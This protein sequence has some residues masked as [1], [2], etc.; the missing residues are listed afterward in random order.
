MSGKPI[1]ACFGL[2]FPPLAPTIAGEVK[3][4]KPVALTVNTD[5]DEDEPHLADRGLT[6]Y[7]ARTAGGKTDIMVARRRSTRQFWPKGAVLEDYVSTEADDRSCFATEGRFP[8]FLYFATKKDRKNTNFDIYVAVRHDVGKAWSA[9]T[10]VN[11][12]ATDADELHPWL[13]ADG[14]ALF[15][16]RKTKDGWRVFVSRRARA[17][18]AGGWGKPEPVAE[19]P[20]D[21]HHA[22]LTPDGKT[23]YLQG[24][25]EKD[26][27]GLFVSTRTASGWGKPAALDELNNA[28]GKTG[29]RSPNLSRDGRLLYFASD[30]PVGKGGLDL[31]YVQ[32]ALLKKR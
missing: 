7:Y 8:Q 18:V 12:I 17:G 15:F 27:W 22:T 16:S 6:L 32:R 11:A 29:D 21:F 4:L 23:M 2:F 5:D 13:T 9:P 28:E 24:P 10:P 20:A 25:L 19:L 26:R 3:P 14:K 31:Y 30:R 1:L